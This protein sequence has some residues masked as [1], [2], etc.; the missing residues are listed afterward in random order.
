MHHRQGRAKLLE[1]ID[2]QGC[3]SK[4]AKELNIPYRVAICHI[5]SIE[6]GI[7]ERLVVTRRGGGG[8]RQDRVNATS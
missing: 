8:R 6:R 5:R 3:I 1:E 4:A 2:K 7:G